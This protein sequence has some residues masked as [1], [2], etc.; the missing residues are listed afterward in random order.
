MRVTDAKHTPE[1]WEHR[2]AG[3][4]DDGA[5]RWDVVQSPDAP[6]A[7]KPQRVIAICWDT[8]DHE[9]LRRDAR[10]NAR[11]IVAAVNACEGIPTEALESGV[12]REMVE[13]LVL[14]Q[15]DTPGYRH[16]LAVEKTRAVLRKLLGEA[17]SPATNHDEEYEEWLRRAEEERYY[18][19]YGREA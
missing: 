13:A 17:S 7:E 4:G 16:K 18:N 19:E 15:F 11:R 10:S 12:V 2:E 14:H 1:P 6:D 9:T 3:R 5:E 8:G